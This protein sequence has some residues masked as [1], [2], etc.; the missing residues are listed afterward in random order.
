MIDASLKNAN[1][2]IVDDQ[3]ANID[4]LTGLLR[5]QKYSNVQ[6]T[7]DPR[8]VVSLYES[9]KPDLIL[10]DL[11]M[12]FMNGFEVMEKLKEIQP[13]NT[14]LPILMLTADVTIESKQRALSVGASDFLTKPFDLP[15]VLLRIKNLLY[16]NYLHQ[17]LKNQN[18]LLEDKVLLRTAE[19]EKTNSELIISRDKAEASDRLKTSF[20]QNISHE[21]RTPLNGILGFTELIAD[22]DIPIEDKLDYVPL[23]KIS[24]RRLMNTITDYVDIATIVSGNLEIQLQELDLISEC[25]KLKN[26]F[27]DLCIVKNLDFNFIYP[28]SNE[29]TR[30]TTD[31]EIFHKIVG[32][33]IDNAIK[34]TKKGSITFGY[35]SDE[36]NIEFFVKDTGVGIAKEAQEVIFESFMQESISNTRGFEGSG[37]GLSIIKGFLA[38]LGGK[39]RLESVK[40]EG[41]TFYFTIPILYELVI[42]PASVPDALK[43]KPDVLPVFLIAEDDD[44]QRLYMDSVLKNLTSMIYHA[45]NGKEAVEICRNHPEITI[46]LMDIKMPVMNGF[47][48]T[49]EIKSF[50]KELPIIAITAYAMRDDEKRAL[51]AGCDDYLAKPSNRD[52]FLKK[53]RVY[54]INF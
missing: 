14:F 38:Q 51:D 29:R 35:K 10:L 9:F 28:E 43:I 6:F 1:I 37:L 32:H 31:L 2:L 18:E 50:R 16:S 5:R 13:A 27:E 7:I 30:L 11:S 40:N 4:V 3:I 25:N 44:T 23:L 47:D 20:I 45:S 21:I 34:F 12:P 46:V 53:L 42:H 8:Q 22:L 39:F 41:T 17:Q 54:G 15:E 49:R 24:S 52:E 19:L 33:L 26:R 48:A 36:T